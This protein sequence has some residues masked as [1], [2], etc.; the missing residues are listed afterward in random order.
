MSCKQAK[1]SL[2]MSLTRSCGACPVKS[3][4]WNLNTNMTKHNNTCRH[5]VREAKF[6]QSWPRL[7]HPRV[8]VHFHSFSCVATLTSSITSGTQPPNTNIR[9]PITVAEWRLRGRGGT[10]WTNGFD[11]D[12]VTARQQND[13]FINKLACSISRRTQIRLQFADARQ[14][15]FSN[16][17]CTSVS[18]DCWQLQSEVVAT[19]ESILSSWLTSCSGIARQHKWSY[20]WKNH[21]V[22]LGAQH[23]SAMKTCLKELQQLRHH[24]D[25]H[26]CHKILRQHK[27]LIQH[28]FSTNHHPSIFFHWKKLQKLQT[29]KLQP[30][31][32]NKTRGQTEMLHTDI[33]QPEVPQSTAAHS[34][35]DDETKV[36][37][38]LVR[39]RDGRVGLAR[40]RR[41]AIDHWNVPCQRARVWLQLQCVQ[42][43][44]ISMPYTCMHT[45][46]QH[47]HTHCHT[48]LPHYCLQSE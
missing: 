13:S 11:Q 46:L 31:L 8:L 21:V 39:V 14:C 35:I 32:T 48:S 30:K 28:Y 27:V 40:W 12:I 1:M 17:V 24:K 45:V 15:N 22:H 23:K 33:K 2:A 38:V 44:Q 34:T 5:K 25:E 29:S 26:S 10:P 3:S 6:E 16:V 18:H 41:L 7:R 43:I 19:P 9:W 4:Y 47:V 36:V 20:T 37:P 42:V